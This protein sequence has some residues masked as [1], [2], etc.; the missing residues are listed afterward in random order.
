MA[1]PLSTGRNRHHR[2]RRRPVRSRSKQLMFKIEK[3]RPRCL[4]LIPLRH[5][6]QPGLNRL[7]RICQ[8]SMRVQLVH[9]A[10][11]SLPFRPLRV[12]PPAPTR[13]SRSPSPGPCLVLA[14]VPRQW[15]SLIM[16]LAIRIR[17]ARSA[18]LR[19][20]CTRPSC[21]PLRRHSCRVPMRP[22]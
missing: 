22:P 11:P 21:A 17:R 8:R 15:P 13:L 2:L 7:C 4:R 9:A 5:T 14:L 20:H 3:R 6:L 1:P 16:L 12:R 18:L 19:D 10:P